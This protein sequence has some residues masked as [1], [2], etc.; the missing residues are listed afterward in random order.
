MPSASLK[1]AADVQETGGAPPRA[2]RRGDE[3]GPGQARGLML[4]NFLRNLFAPARADVRTPDAASLAALVRA[5][6]QAALLDLLHDAPKPP[7]PIDYVQIAYLL[8]AADSARY[9]TAHMRNASD[10][11]GQLPLL[12]A[13]LEQCSVDGLVLE[14]GVYQGKTLAVIAGAES[15]T[16]HGFDSFAGLPED[17]TYFQ[18]K[19]RFAL[20]GVPQLAASNV[21]LHVGWFSDTLPG[22]LAAHSGPVR[23]LHIDSDLYS[24]AVTVLEGL[25]ARIVAGTIILF[26]EYLNY[27]GWEQDEFRAFQEFVARHGVTYE[28]TGFA[29]SHHSVAARITEIAH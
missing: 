9:F 12:E 19:G 17:W 21:E 15:R 20:D 6:S 29:S 25:A 26:D 10:Y 27:P 8:A 24:S 23:F 4:G 14:F 16:V 7:R 28:Y 22:F 13:A 11:G 3:A 2:R 18:K 1:K 5:Q